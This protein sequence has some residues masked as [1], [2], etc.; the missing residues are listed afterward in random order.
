VLGYKP[1][2]I[3]VCAANLTAFTGFIGATSNALGHM[4]VSNAQHVSLRSHKGYR[5]VM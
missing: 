3:E 1:R 2:W 5:P 4:R